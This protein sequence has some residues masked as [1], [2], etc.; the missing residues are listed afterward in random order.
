MRRWDPRHGLDER[1]Q[2]VMDLFEEL[3]ATQPP[4]PRYCSVDPIA[5]SRM[6]APAAI[7]RY[8]REDDRGH[9]HRVRRDRRAAK[10]PNS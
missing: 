3:K 2:R 5:L 4:R 10:P 6:L 9:R 7:E 1:Q 8:I